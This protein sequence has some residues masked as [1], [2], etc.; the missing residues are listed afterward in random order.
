VLLARHP[1]GLTDAELARL[2]GWAHPAVNQICRQLAAEQLIRRDDLG[3]PIM[4]Y[5]VDAAAQPRRGQLKPR[6]TAEWFW[7]GNVQATV[8]RHLA[9]LGAIVQ[10]VADTATKARGTDVVATLGGR[11]VH[12]EVKGWPS[13]SYADPRRASEI[14]RTQ[15]TLQ[16]NTGTP[17]PC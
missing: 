12:I 15:P 8:V 11:H 14:K 1:D 16:A 6:R 2:T 13:T 9:E 10:S 17:M 7:E 3:R 5:P 4:N